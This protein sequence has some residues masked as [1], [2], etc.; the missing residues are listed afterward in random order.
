M[1]LVVIDGD[2]I[3]YKVSAA[4]EKRSIIVTHKQSGRTKEWNTRT[5]F[6]DWLAVSDKW[7]IEDFDIEDKQT[8]EP[9]EFCLN[10]VKQM[11]NNIRKMSGCTEI[12]L[13]V[14]GTG[15]FRDDLLLPTKY[16][17][18]RSGNIR[19]LLL[20]EVKEYIIRKY[21]AELAHGL[22]SDDI[23]SM[24]AYE[25]FRSKK[26]IVQATVDKD[27]KMCSGWLLN[28]DKMTEP[29]FISGLGTL[30]I[31]GKGK[32]DG[33]GRKWLMYQASVGDPSD[34]YKPTELT[35][36]KYGEKSALKDFGELQT[37]KECW[38]C[39]ATLYRMWYPEQF[40]YTAWNGQQVE[41]DYLH[42]MQLYIDAAHMRRFKEDKLN[43]KEI[44]GKLGVQYE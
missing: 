38:E 20:G 23:L 5:E 10:T 24:Y 40:T 19:P 2:L 29:K 43:V 32:L 7:Q 27:A 41:A 3:G 1:S 25:G 18:S 30:F 34:C 26:K 12:K 17:S 16:K 35:K 15:N 14:Q 37:D 8:P 33:C 36:Y 42:M 9:I 4:C 28:W 39:L 44:L 6:K 13:V 11:V 21:K 31:D 22:E